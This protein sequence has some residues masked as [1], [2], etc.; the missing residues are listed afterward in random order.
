MTNKRPNARTTK[1]PKRRSSASKR[2]KKGF[3]EKLLTPSKASKRSFRRLGYVACAVAIVAA[4]FF[5]TPLSSHLSLLTSRSS[6][7]SAR[8]SYHGIDISKHQGRI[9]WKTVAKDRNIQFVYIKATEGASV[10]DR[11]YQKNLREARAAGLRVGS[12]HFFRA[13]KSAREQFELFKRH[14]KKGQQDLIPMVDVEETGNRQV[15]RQRLQRN[16]REFMELMKKHYGKYPLLYSQYRFYNE[17]LAPEFNRYFIFI[18]RY[19]KREPVLKGGGKYNIWQYS[20]RGRIKG[21]EGY[22]DLDRF[23]NGTTIRDIEL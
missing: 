1:R 16:L 21:I 23:A 15:S 7:G 12:Y 6:K 9:N 4:L 14:V 20:E 8:S 18:A 5:C 22:V 2:G 13:Y 17:K 11:H 19:G 10:V 3:L